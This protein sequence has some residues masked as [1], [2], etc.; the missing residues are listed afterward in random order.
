MKSLIKASE[1]RDGLLKINRQGVIYYQ[2][3]A[4]K[5]RE[6][7]PKTFFN[8]RLVDGRKY[9]STQ[10]REI[11]NPNV[12]IDNNPTKKNKFYHFRMKVKAIIYK[13]YELDQP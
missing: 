4:E 6:L 7:N 9:E 1:I 3:A 12:D 5:I 11:T 13:A 10:I 2:K 8:G